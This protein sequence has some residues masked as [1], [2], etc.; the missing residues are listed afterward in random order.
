MTTLHIIRHNASSE[1]LST[2]LALVDNGDAILLLDQGNY[3][4]NNTEFIALT[5]TY[6]IFVLTEQCNALAIE[7]SPSITAIN[8]PD[9][10]ELMTHYQRTITWQ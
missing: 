10:V 5:K 4:L 9:M 6:P 1:S 3:L 7:F 2:S 8:Y